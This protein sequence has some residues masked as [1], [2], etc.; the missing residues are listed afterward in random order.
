MSGYY[1]LKGVHT[2]PHHACAHFGRSEHIGQLAPQERPGAAPQHKHSAPGSRAPA[3]A[4][5]A[6]AAAAETCT[7]KARMS[8]GM[9]AGCTSVLK[10]P[11]GCL[12]RNS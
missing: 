9:R 11:Q 10:R 12:D 1:I 7:R 3:D 6:P 8:W 4:A 5:A 2:L